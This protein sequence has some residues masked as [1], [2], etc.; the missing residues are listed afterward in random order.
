M[1]IALLNVEACHLEGLEFDLFDTAGRDGDIQRAQNMIDTYQSSFPSTVLL[2]M[3]GRC[4]TDCCLQ[5]FLY[6]ECDTT[7]SETLAN[8]CF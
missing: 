3:T 4:E 1:L 6:L 2:A 8:S 5:I 7:L